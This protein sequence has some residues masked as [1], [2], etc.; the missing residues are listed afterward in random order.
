MIARDCPDDTPLTVDRTLSLALTSAPDTTAGTTMLW[1]A[2]MVIPDLT[3]GAN[4]TIGLALF[5][6][7]TFNPTV[8][9][10]QVTT[11]GAVQFVWF[12]N[13]TWTATASFNATVGTLGG[14]GFNDGDYVHLQA[15][16]YDGGGMANI[17]VSTKAGKHDAWT[18]RETVVAGHAWAGTQPV[19]PH[20]LFGNGRALHYATM[21]VDGVPWVNYDNCRTGGGSPATI[22]DT[23]G[24]VF[25]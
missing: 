18:F 12:A 21:V 2:G 10:V 6:G 9:L 25:S 22:Q 5:N 7:A 1:R 8:W 20:S 14:W 24:K 15:E 4:F 13:G 11:T 19:T 17:D 23:T 16:V 3:P